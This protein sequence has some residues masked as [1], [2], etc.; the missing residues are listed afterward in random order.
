MRVGIVAEQLR[1][2][3]PG[4]IGTYTTGLLRGLVELDDGSLDVVAITS[5]APA[6][7]PLVGL[8]VEVVASALGHRSMVQL[9]EWGLGRPRGDYDVLHLT[10]MAG[11]LS[12]GGPLTTV[13]VHD[14]AWRTHPELTTSRGARWHEAGLKRAERSAK[15]IIT[16]SP[17]VAAM[18]VD[19]GVAPERVAVIGEGS[20]HLPSADHEAAASLLAQHLVTG[21]F[22]LTVST[23]EPRK[24]LARLVEAHGAAHGAG[25]IP[26]IIVGPA[27]WGPDVDAPP[28][29][30]LA[31]AQ[32]GSVLAALYERCA[33]FVYV[34]LAEGFGLPPLE[35][36]AH[37]AAVI[38]S[39]TVPSVRTAPDVVLVDPHDT[40]ALASALAVAMHDTVSDER[41]ARARG[42][43]GRHR[44]RDVAA[45][46]RAL[47]ERLS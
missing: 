39:S 17:E 45:E 9:W 35:A 40:E 1:Q 43:A 21:P 5:R 32:R 34:P 2:K 29:V 15:A 12:G 37:G 3:I 22:L 19:D 11:P 23:L 20:D 31:G 46:H 28:G 24:N 30:V 25:E 14:L 27:G 42:F 7:D 8:G 38:A 41:R 13:M 16:P 26:L 33:A 10:S 6:D 4:G 18:L 36:M 44:W 47:W